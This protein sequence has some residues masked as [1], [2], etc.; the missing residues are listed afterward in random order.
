MSYVGARHFG[1]GSTCS[2][3]LLLIRDCSWG[4]AHLHLR[5]EV[6]AVTDRLRKI[7]TWPTSY[8]AFQNWTVSHLRTSA[9]RESPQWDGQPSGKFVPDYLVEPMEFSAHYTRGLLEVQLINFGECKS[10]MQALP[11]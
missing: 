10:F 11:L 6:I 8:S 1:V 5:I 4:W 2:Q 7:F 3:L 9:N